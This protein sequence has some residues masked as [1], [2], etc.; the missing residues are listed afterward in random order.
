MALKQILDVVVDI[1]AN[2]KEMKKDIAQ[3]KEKQNGMQGKLDNVEAKI[4]KLTTEQIIMNQKIAELQTDTK[5]LNFNMNRLLREQEDT[6][7]IIGYHT[8]KLGEL[9]EKFDRYVQSNGSKYM[10]N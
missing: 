8:Q 10:Y 3:I 6:K 5:L 9:Y 7:N 1:K 4:E 2:Q